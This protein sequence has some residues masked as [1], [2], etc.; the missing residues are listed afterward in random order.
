MRLRSGDLDYAVRD[1]EKTVNDVAINGLVKRL[2]MAAGEIGA[3]CNHFGGWDL[4]VSAG[5]LL[6]RRAESARRRLVAPMP[7][8]SEEAYTES[9]SARGGRKPR[10]TL[11]PSRYDRPMWSLLY[12]V[13]RA[14]ASLLVS[15]G[16]PGRADG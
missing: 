11:G 3:N 7:P 4:A 16:P 10:F 2:V 15:A 5:P 14:L 13:A 12:L 1:D 6:N 8:Y 9:A